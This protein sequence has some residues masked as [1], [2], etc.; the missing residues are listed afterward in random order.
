MFP[1]RQEFYFAAN[2]A[3]LFFAGETIV[4]VAKIEKSNS[5]SGV[6]KL[7]SFL[8]DP[9]STPVSDEVNSA[10]FSIDSLFSLTNAG[11]VIIYAII[12]FIFLILFNLLRD[13]IIARFQFLWLF[14]K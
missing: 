2:S 13:G 8:S 7:V 4:R 14:Q 12:V 6:N 10:I 9:T 11:S 5:V 1:P 3:A